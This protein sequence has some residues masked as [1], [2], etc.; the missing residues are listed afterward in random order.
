[1]S[2]CLVAYYS[3]SGK[4]AKFAKALATMLSADLEEIKDVKRRSGV[5]GYMRSAFEASKKTSAPIEPPTKTLKDY[6]IIVLGCPVWAGNMASPM[7]SFILRERHNIKQ[8][9]LFCTLGGAGGEATLESM[10][11]LSG[12]TPVAS[13]Q[14]RDAELAAGSWRGKIG[15]FAGA[16]RGRLSQPLELSTGANQSMLQNP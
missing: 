6:D 14:M 9:A 4:T 16:I 15:L 11:A 5:L 7:R 2:K 3:W 8:L 13:L 10:A 1:M 12:K